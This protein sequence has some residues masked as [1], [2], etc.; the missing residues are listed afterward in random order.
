M[1]LGAPGEKGTLGEKGLPGD[2][3]YGIY[4]FSSFSFSTIEYF[5]VGPRGNNGAPGRTG[6]KLI[7]LDYK[8]K[9]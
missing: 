6:C 1:I 9:N 5:S 7:F 3:T 4:I 8:A 2:E